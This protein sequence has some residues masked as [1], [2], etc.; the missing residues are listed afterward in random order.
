MPA[1]LDLSLRDD[2]ARNTA[3]GVAA[4][5][6]MTASQPQT[7]MTTVHRPI[8]V[9]DVVGS[10][11]PHSLTTTVTDTVIK[12]LKTTGIIPAHHP[13]RMLDLGAHRDQ[14]GRSR[15]GT[16]PPDPVPLMRATDLLIVASPS[17]LLTYSGVLKALLDDLG[18]M[19]LHRIVTLA[20]SVEANRRTGTGRR[21]QKL[22]DQLGAV[23]PAPPLIITRPE[24]PQHCITRWATA[25]NCVLLQALA[26]LDPCLQARRHASLPDDS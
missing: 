24:D 10:R 3:T 15:H 4:V 2:G 18:P 26:Q 8:R 25:H 19:S 7:G 14:T 6:R 13:V 16:R 1:D 22:L 11:A 5:Q 21:L 9:T 12:A 17:Y 23:L 20:I